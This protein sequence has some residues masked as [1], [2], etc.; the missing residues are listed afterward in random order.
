VNAESEDEFATACQQLLTR[1]RPTKLYRLF[2]HRVL[3]VLLASSAR[4]ILSQAFLDPSVKPKKAFSLE[5]HLGI[6]VPLALKR[7][8][9]V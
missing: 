2:T 5:H 7:S 8:F 3:L 4:R 6:A 9:F 1:V